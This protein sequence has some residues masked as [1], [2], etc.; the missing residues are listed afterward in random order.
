[1][2]ELNCEEFRHISNGGETCIAYDSTGEFVITGG[3]D[4]QLFQAKYKSDSSNEF[5]PTIDDD[6]LCLA[7]KNDKL[8]VGTN[9]HKLYL[10]TPLEDVTSED[11]DGDVA[12][13]D[14]LHTIATFA[15][16]VR[17]VS[18]RS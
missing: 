17:S 7:V 4:G 3:E 15:N 16:P 11:Y 8:A 18:F 9:G 14:N 12:D 1:M 6:I 10:I 2:E 5:H 13:R